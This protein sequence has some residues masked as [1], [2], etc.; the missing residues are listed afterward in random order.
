M[1]MI[2][3]LTLFSVFL[4]QPK[5]PGLVAVL[6]TIGSLSEAF[7][8][9]V[10]DALM[11]IQSRKDLQFGSQDWVILMY[12]SKGTGGTI[13]CIF[14]GFVTNDLHPKWCFFATSIMGIIVTIF[15][16]L[17]NKDSESESKCKDNS[18]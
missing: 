14:G 11:V 8:N 17:L 6:L 9:V 16:V 12:I 4:F 3:F 15:A 10:A 13:G 5:Q 18:V 2:Q 1:G 7:T